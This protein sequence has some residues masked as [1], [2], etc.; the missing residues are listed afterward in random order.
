MHKYTRMWRALNPPFQQT[1]SHN[2]SS[3]SDIDVTHMFLLC[4]YAKNI[5][6]V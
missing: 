3:L 2:L 5:S 6:T 1:S 4:F